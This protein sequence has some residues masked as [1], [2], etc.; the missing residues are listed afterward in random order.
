MNDITTQVLFALL[1]SAMR[2]TPMSDQEKALYDS[3]QLA[4]LYR[5]SQKHDIA[6][7]VG[8]ALKNNALP[9]DP[10]LMK[11]FIEKQFVAVFRYEQLNYAQNQLFAALEAAQIP[12]LPLKGSVIRE[13]YPQPWLRTSC[14]VDVL[15]P[16][17]QLESAVDYLVQQCD[18]IRQ[19]KGSHDVALRTPSRQNIELHYTLIEDDHA[20]AHVLADIWNSAIPKAGCQY[21]HIMPDALTYYYH[22]AHM[23]KH[24]E[25]GGCGIRPLI[26]LWLLDKQFH[27]TKSY[28]ELLE[29]GGLLRFAEAVRKLSRVWLEGAEADELSLQLQDYILYGGVYGAREN[30][31]KVHQVKKGG[32][33]SYALSRIFL[34][35]D[36]LKYQ[37]PVL[38]KHRWLMPV[39]QVRRWCRL[40]FGGRLKHVVQELSYNQEIRMEQMDETKMFLSQLGLL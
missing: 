16:Q 5:L 29:Q 34:R 2:G 33:G 8:V 19:G 36:V 31:V 38:E 20:G 14:D 40:I 1:R 3:N 12:F 39:C 4:V 17:T 22:I 25:L 9:G 37:Y 23:A 13:Y 21:W 35:H 26:D 11:R 7:L 10:E 28:D 18:Y 27:D 15:V 24:F 32:K 6:H 30:R